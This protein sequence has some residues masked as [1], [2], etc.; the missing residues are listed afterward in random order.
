MKNWKASILEFLSA[1]GLALLIF[2]L[3]SSAHAAGDMPPENA[4]PLVI[5]PQYEVIVPLNCTD[6]V[7]VMP[8]RVVLGMGRVN[9]LLARENDGRRAELQKAKEG[10]KC[11]VLEVLPPP[12]GGRS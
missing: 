6:G 2:A 4:K 9:A 12:R 8:E 1:V 5:E 11:A 10:K 3:I 7:C